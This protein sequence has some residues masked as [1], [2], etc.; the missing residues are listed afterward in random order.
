MKRRLHDLKIAALVGENEPGLLGSYV[1]AYRSMGCT[2]VCWDPHAALRRHTKF[3]RFGR[4]AVSF[5]PVDAWTHKA[6]REMIL[7]LAQEQPDV[8]LV[9]GNAPIRAGALSQLRIS[10]PHAQVVLLWPDSLLNLW[11]HTIEAL[12]A[13]DLVA[14]YSRSTIP[15]FLRLGARSVAWVPFAADTMQFSREVSIADPERR[16]LQSD[17]CFIGNHRP[18]REAAIAA[19]VRAGLSVKVWGEPNSW[20]RHARD[21]GLVSTYFQGKPLYAE[22]FAKAI[23]CSK[24]CLNPIDPT[25]FPA[26]NMR[27]FEIPASGGVALNSSCPEMANIFGEGHA[28]FYF[29]SVDSLPAMARELI[30]DSSLRSRIA[31]VAHDLV[32]RDH[33]YI[34]RAQEILRLLGLD[35][36]EKEAIST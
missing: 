31:D 2:V 10:V 7:A 5:L 30:A 27:F 3:G 19:L 1:R 24:L 4:Y 9:S 23:R 15:E 28:A 33:T 32:T 13:Y 8:V 21:K 16:E 20:R 26:A 34:H 18:E 14:T 11:R 36:S 25:T 35:G 17:V 22:A 6:N 29:D 12:P